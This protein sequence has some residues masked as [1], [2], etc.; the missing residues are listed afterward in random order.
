MNNSSRTGTQQHQPVL[1][2]ALRDGT[3][4]S[5]IFSRE[6]PVCKTL[7]FDVG[8]LTPDWLKDSKY[9]G[10]TAAD[11]FVTNVW[12]KAKFINYYA[13]KVGC[14]FGGLM[15]IAVN[16]APACTKM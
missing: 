14:C 5:F 2:R 1:C 7:H 15:L 12:T 3:G 13:D 16:K 8:I 10:Q 6:Q 4:T 11:N 9:L